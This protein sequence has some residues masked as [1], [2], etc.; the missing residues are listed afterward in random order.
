MEKIASIKR[1]MEMPDLCFTLRVAV[2]T[3]GEDPVAGL[4]PNSGFQVGVVRVAINQKGRYLI[5][6]AGNF[7]TE[8]DAEKFLP[9]LKLGLWNLALQYNVSFI[10]DFEKR[11]ITRSI[12]PIKAGQNLAINF[13]LPDIGP[14]HGLADEGGFAIFPSKENIRFF[15]MGDAS[16]RSSTQMSDVVRVLAEGIEHF[17][18]SNNSID[19]AFCT[20]LDLYLSQFQEVSIRARFLTLMMALEVLAPITEKHTVTQ[21]LLLELNQRIDI[22]K[23]CCPDEDARDALDALQHELKFRKET[24]IRRRVRRLILDETILEKEEKETLA[25]KVVRAYDLRGKLA[26]TGFVNLSDLY[27]AHDIVFN[28]VKLILQTRLGFITSLEN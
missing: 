5:L 9:R 2:K 19:D 25:R 1:E 8:L 11:E 16:G 14:V 24:S 28:A 18:P 21:K 27:E 12:D 10:S 20:A 13:G 17:E 22:E 6:K 26:H 7:A 4:E 23:S 15:G 3:L